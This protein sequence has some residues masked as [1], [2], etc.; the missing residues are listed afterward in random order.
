MMPNDVAT[1]SG[2][3]GSSNSTDG[4]DAPR[5]RD[6]KREY[7]PI[8]QEPPIMCITITDSES[9]DEVDNVELPLHER[10]AA[11]LTAE[12]KNEWKSEAVNEKKKLLQITGQ[13]VAA[14]ELITD[15]E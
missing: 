3:S 14:R 8:N 11:H 6:I 9:E 13:E 2:H 7:S 1:M 10:V 12:R 4:A 15:Q 5:G